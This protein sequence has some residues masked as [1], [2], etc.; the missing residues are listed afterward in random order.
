MKHR[1]THPLVSTILGII[2]II[3][4]VVLLAKYIWDFFQIFIGIASL[5]LGIFFLTSNK[6]SLR[7]YRF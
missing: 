1:A 5:V 4:A 2:L 6:Y 7:F 3:I